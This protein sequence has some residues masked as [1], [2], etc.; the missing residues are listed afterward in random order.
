MHS[1][2]VHLLKFSR[3]IILT[4]CFCMK[5]ISSQ[6]IQICH[7]GEWYQ[8]LYDEYICTTEQLVNRFQSFVS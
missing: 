4:L 8:D 3:W 1:I 7:D 6:Y 5:G 2:H